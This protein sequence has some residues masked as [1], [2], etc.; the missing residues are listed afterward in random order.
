MEQH[1][2]SSSKDANASA[3]DWG[4]I[5][6]FEI[7]FNSCEANYCLQPPQNYM[8][9]ARAE[10]CTDELRAFWP[11]V[12]DFVNGVEGAELLNASLARAVAAGPLDAYP[13]YFI[14]G[15]YAGGR[16]YD[17]PIIAMICGNYTGDPPE[18]CLPYL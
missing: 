15:Q 13:A 2:P 7:C 18:G 3:D 8:T 10:R 12:R 17:T 4:P 1:L 11:D 14:N 5:L 16:P 9:P 6:D